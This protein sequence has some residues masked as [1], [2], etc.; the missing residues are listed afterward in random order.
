MAV[1]GR[2]TTTV[3]KLVLE[4]LRDCAP[5]AFERAGGMAALPLEGPSVALEPYRACLHRIREDAGDIALLR[6]GRALERISDPFLFV[7][8]NSDSVALLLE[9]DARLGRFVHSRHRIA[10]LEQSPTRLLIAHRSQVA[11][12]PLAVESLTAAGQYLVL[13]E[14]LGCHDLRMRLPGSVEPT[15]WIYDRGAYHPPPPGDHALWEFTWSSFAPTRRPMRGLDEVLLGQD[16]RPA[17]HESTATAGAVE[18]VVRRDLSRTWT[19]H[20]VAKQLSLAPRSLQRALLSE[21]TRFSDLLDRIRVEE[22]AHLLRTTQLSITEI[23]YACGFADTS[24]CSRRFK[25]RMG[26]P[27]SA[28][29]NQG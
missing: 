13:L 5:Q 16:D 12:A 27:P 9:K 10:V 3:V 15:R 23:G 6:A 7:L 25:L 1:P 14:Q 18:R 28:Y 19:L 11:E 17:L 8:L 22:V 4:G 29:R 2:I 21:G 20:E 26:C 24:H